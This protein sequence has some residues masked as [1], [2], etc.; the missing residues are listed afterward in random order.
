MTFFF[1]NKILTQRPFVVFSVF[2]YLMIDNNH[3]ITEKHFKYFVNPEPHCLNVMLVSNLSP[4]PPVFVLIFVMSQ[5]DQFLFGNK[6]Q[7]K[8]S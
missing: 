5:L 2:L 4:L 6:L 8:I 3:M 1:L 7:T